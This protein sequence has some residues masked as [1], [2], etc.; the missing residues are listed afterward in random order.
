MINKKGKSLKYME[1]VLI[2]EK[3]LV[4]RIKDVQNDRG[5]YLFVDRKKEL[6]VGK[7]MC[8]IGMKKVECVF[9]ESV[10]KVEKIFN[11]ENKGDILGN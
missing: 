9:F 4:K 6:V 7:V 1:N 10:C 8:S 2:I 3:F 5:I 11:I